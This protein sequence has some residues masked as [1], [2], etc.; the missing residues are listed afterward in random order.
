[1]KGSKTTLMIAL[2]IGALTA[3]VS[4]AYLINERA[5]LAARQV[6]IYVIAKEMQPGAKVKTNDVLERRVPD[7]LIPNLP[8]QPIE[9]KDFASETRQALTRPVRANEILSRDMFIP[10]TDAIDSKIEVGK[11]G[12]PLPINARAASG[13]IRPGMHVDIAA[14]FTDPNKKNP[15]SLKVIEYVKVIAVGNAT[16]DDGKSRAANYSTITV[17]L[18]PEDAMAMVTISKFVGKDGFDVILRNKQDDD[19]KIVKINEEV[20]KLVGLE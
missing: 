11:R 18:S 16:E 2:L 14:T 5:K 6:K 17:E 20:R 8:V 15:V 4:V 19:A 3:A 1:M 13:I 10:K 7:Y 12:V 9:E